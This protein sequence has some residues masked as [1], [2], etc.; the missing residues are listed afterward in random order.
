MKY[1]LYGPDRWQPVQKLAV[2]VKASVF[3]LGHDGAYT[4]PS[5]A[6]PYLAKQHAHFT[7][8]EPQSWER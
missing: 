3:W 8:S 7:V 1:E 5:R 4:K 6:H 2:M